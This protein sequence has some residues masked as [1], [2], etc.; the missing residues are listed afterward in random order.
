MVLCCVDSCLYVLSS[1]CWK[2]VSAWTSTIHNTYFSNIVN[3]LPALLRYYTVR[4]CA[5]RDN[6]ELIC[7]L[8]VTLEGHHIK[9]MFSSNRTVICSCVCDKNQM[10]GGTLTDDKDSFS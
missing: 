1:T 2:G 5:E 4:F 10:D 9:Y 6:E 7:F 8:T 3:F